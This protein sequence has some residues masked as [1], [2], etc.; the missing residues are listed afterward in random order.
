L[1]P[2]V[3]A[4]LSIIMTAN[5]SPVEELAAYVT[6]DPGDGAKHP[7]LVEVGDPPSE[8]VAAADERVVAPAAAPAASA[9]GGGGAGGAGGGAESGFHAA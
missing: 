2:E 6:L 8:P 1:I 7:V 4:L 3:V 9:R 5:R